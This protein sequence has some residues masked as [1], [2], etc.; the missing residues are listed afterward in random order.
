MTPRRGIVLG[1][2]GVLGGTWAVGALVA[3]EQVHGVRADQADVIVGT[4]VGSVLGALLGAGVTPEQLRQHYGDERVTD[5]PLRGLEWDPD[6]AVG[7]HRPGLPSGL[8]PGSLRLLAATLRHPLAVRP[9][10]VV[11]GL[12]PTGGRSLAGVGRLIDAVTP[13]GEWS[14]HPACWVVAMD[15]D[16]GRRVVF[17]IGRAH[18]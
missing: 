8:G 9:S 14:A 18:V 10:T 12:M 15:Y 3:L 16:T 1:G 13:F 4:S 7:G 17:E 6:A 5:G 11:A 2:G